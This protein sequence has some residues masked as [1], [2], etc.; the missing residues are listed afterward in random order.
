[1]LKST[2]GILLT[3][4]FAM[5][6]ALAAEIE[7]QVVRFPERRN[8]KL[9]MLPTRR[10]PRAQMEA[11]IKYEQG[12]A[13]IEISYNHMKP[14]VLFGGD[15][16]CYVLWVVNRDGA[17][18]NL[19]EL[20]ARPEADKDTLKFST[21]LRTF[22]LLITA[23]PYYQ[24]ARPSELVIFWNHRSSDPQA[25]SDRLLFSGLVPPP[26]Y[27]MESLA[28]VKYD[29]KAPLDAVQAER[30][31]EIAGRMKAQEYAPQIYK[32]AH[33]TL[34]QAQAMARSSGSRRSVRQYARRSVASSN[35]AIKVTLRRLEEKELEE[36]IAKRQAEI[37]ALEHRAAEAETRVQKLQAESQATIASL[38]HEK[39]KAEA[40]VG[41]A[42]SDLQRIRQERAR[43]EAEKDELESTVGNLRREQTDLRASMEALLREKSVLEGRLQQALS[44]VADT[45]ESARGF[46]VNLPDILFDVGRAT[47]KPE[48]QLV[49][50]K[51]AG[52]FLIMQDL[53][54]QIEGHTDSTGSASF[55][56]RL[57]R[58]RA[59]S[60]FDF[61]VRQGIASTR[62]AAVGHGFE[63]PIAD[64][65]TAEG[66]RQNR[67][68]EIIIGEGQLAD[69]TSGERSPGGADGGNLS[70]RPSK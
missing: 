57:S 16:T 52:I 26:R 69:E 59:D 38:E 40:A 37:Q 60:V 48:A 54:S 28:P 23:E 12:Q 25:P 14:A 32:E 62:I 41:Q 49:I 27:G 24:V 17:V 6:P 50:A 51:L 66:R 35:E 20:W 7:L 2:F 55:N 56:L 44:L 34:Q 30:V 53:N 29:K 36:R 46:I 31:F 1:M 68:V 5:Q 18:E 15:V 61:L 4:C 21:G 8:V 33:V 39:Q 10:V 43:M 64:N 45:R 9:S 70:V 11:K 19:G 13:R 65:A 42:Q 58:E 67:R 47:L 22:A 63:R 3:L